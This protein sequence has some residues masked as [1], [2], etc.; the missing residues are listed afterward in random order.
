MSS[1]IFTEK[2]YTVLINFKTQLFFIQIHLYFEIFILTNLFNNIKQFTEKKTVKLTSNLPI[3]YMNMH[4]KTHYLQEWI[5]Y[6]ENNPK[7][8]PSFFTLS[9]ILSPKLQS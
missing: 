3:F 7:L 4:S 8:C 5:L 9:G 6:V 2:L 1:F